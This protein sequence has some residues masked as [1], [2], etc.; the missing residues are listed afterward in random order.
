MNYV[1]AMLIKIEDDRVVVID[2]EKYLVLDKGVPEKKDLS[3]KKTATPRKRK[4]RAKKRPPSN[5]RQAAL[6]ALILKMLDEHPKAKNSDVRAWLKNGHGKDVTATVVGSSLRR[7]KEKD[8]VEVDGIKNGAAWSLK[9]KP[10][11]P[12][13]VFSN[14]F[15]APSLT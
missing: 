11:P 10:V 9:Q 2:G 3:L 1:R 6:D 13:P 8:L 14:A 12:S 5:G 7:L 15:S 4:S